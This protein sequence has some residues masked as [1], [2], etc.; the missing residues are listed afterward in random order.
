MNSLNSSN[1]QFVLNL[2][3]FC[4][5]NSFRPDSV[6]SF[7]WFSEK[8]LKVLRFIRKFLKSNKTEGEPEAIEQTRIMFQ[9]CMNTSKYLIEEQTTFQSV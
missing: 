2:P 4:F 8:Q 7:D 3:R 1:S 6:S 9:A 5:S